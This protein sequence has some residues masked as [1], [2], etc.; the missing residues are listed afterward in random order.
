MSKTRDDNYNINS[1]G[2]L[3]TIPKAKPLHILRMCADGQERAMTTYTE[4][5]VHIYQTPPMP[6]DI[7]HTLLPAHIT[8]T[9]LSTV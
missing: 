8:H 7:T 1:A 6:T 3:K 9:L 5:L 2:K 4:P